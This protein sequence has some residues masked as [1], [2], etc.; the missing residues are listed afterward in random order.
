MTELCVAP[1]MKNY[2][3]FISE[4]GNLYSTTAPQP[5]VSAS[6]NEQNNNSSLLQAVGDNALLLMKNI[7]NNVVCR[8]CRRC[9]CLPFLQYQIFQHYQLMRNK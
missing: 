6:L 9:A 7:F 3:V 8:F 1:M 4:P 5:L 2:K